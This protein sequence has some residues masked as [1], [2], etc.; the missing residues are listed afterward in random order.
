MAQLDDRDLA[1]RL[2]L[3]M[4]HNEDRLDKTED[5]KI[6]QALDQ[7]IGNED[8]KFKRFIGLL[9]TNAVQVNKGQ[10]RAL[11][12][13]FSFLSHSCITNARHVIEAQNNEFRISVYAQVAIA[14]G[15]EI[16]ITYINLLRSTLERRENLQ[17]VWHFTCQCSRC[18]DPT[19]LGTFLG[20]MAF[21]L[22]FAS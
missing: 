4:D 11:F 22:L 10:A 15:Q 3:L 8:Y 21:F 9:K 12:P 1:L 14:E 5:E 7:I 6:S 2:D 18:K 19:E 16:C 13:T 20:T 17:C